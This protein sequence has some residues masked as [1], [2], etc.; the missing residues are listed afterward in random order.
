MPRFTEDNQFL[1]LLTPSICWGFPSIGDAL[2]PLTF[3]H[4]PAQTDKLHEF[5]AI[6]Q[7]NSGQ[8]R[9]LPPMSDE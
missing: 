2:F 9:R 7:F 5:G 4:F 3:Y 1:A 8:I 6:S